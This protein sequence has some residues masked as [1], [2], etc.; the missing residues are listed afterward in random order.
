[1]DLAV[2][3]HGDP[4]LTP[5]VRPSAAVLYALPSRVRVPTVDSWNLTVQHE[6]TSHLY[7]E[8]AY[9]GDKGTHV[10]ADS[11]AGTYYD[12]SQPFLQGLIVPA[13]G[14]ATGNCKGGR[15]GL[16]PGINGQN[17][18]LTVPTVRSFYQMV[19]IPYDPCPS[20][21]KC[22]FNPNLFEIRYFGNNAN[23]N[24]N[25]LQA[26]VL[27]NLNRGYSFMAHYTWS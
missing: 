19:E 23:D 18:C 7:L 14:G 25:S 16:F 27:K 20:K 21:Q 22:F 6:L 8:L 13:K 11:N 12:L 2:A 26:K 10:F 15:R 5:P 17:F 9:V 3:N 1:M 24:Y 4:S